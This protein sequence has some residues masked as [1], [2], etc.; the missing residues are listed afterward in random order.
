MKINERG[1][2]ENDTAE[3]HEHDEG[4]AKALYNFFRGKSK[5]FPK[6][7]V[8]DVGC[9]DG[10]YVNYI[11]KAGNMDDVMV[12]GMDGNP[13]TV[14]LAGLNTFVMDVTKP[15]V[16]HK[17]D[18][19]L[20][21]EVGE[22]IPSELEQMFLENLD[23]LNKNGIVLSWAI[24]GQGGDGHIN[25][26]DNWEVIEKIEPLGYTLDIEASA[27]LRISCSEYPKPCYWFKDTIM[28]FIKNQETC[29]LGYNFAIGD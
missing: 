8:I 9:G 7:F 4:L 11:N 16:H 28:V 2:W 25:C 20:C 22:H 26:K 23:N 29:S 10:Y 18:W 17:Y 19:V 14:E 12:W 3:G 15:L 27:K 6:T 13:H 1:F 5:D 24:R 21:L